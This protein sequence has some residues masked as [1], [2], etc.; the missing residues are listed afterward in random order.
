M[1]YQLSYCIFFLGLLGLLS[2]QKILKKQQFTWEKSV[3]FSRGVGQII[4]LFL[5]RSP[6]VSE[7]CIIC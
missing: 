2:N 5:K 4:A 6:F 3:S 1:F 7:G